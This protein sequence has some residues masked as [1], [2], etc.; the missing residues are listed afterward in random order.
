MSVL[1]FQCHDKMG[2]LGPHIPDKIGTP[3]V[4]WGPLIGS[5]I[6][7]NICELLAYSLTLDHC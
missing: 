6:T 3:L 1:G 2:T 4:N 7:T 5:H